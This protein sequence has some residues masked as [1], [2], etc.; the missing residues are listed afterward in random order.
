MTYHLLLLAAAIIFGVVATLVGFNV[1][2][3][4][5]YA[6]GWLSL[7]VTLGLASRLP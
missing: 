4:G 3:D 6:V 1:L 5:D 7:A 2:T